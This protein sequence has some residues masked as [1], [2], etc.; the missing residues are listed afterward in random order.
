[1]NKQPPVVCETATIR[2]TGVFVMMFCP[3]CNGSFSESDTVCD[4][5]GKL[6]I[7]DGATSNEIQDLKVRVEI[8]E[9]TLNELI[10]A[11]RGNYDE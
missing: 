11:I 5:C 1:L 8:L 6:L 2:E 10:Y 3:T 4:K 7:K 9:S